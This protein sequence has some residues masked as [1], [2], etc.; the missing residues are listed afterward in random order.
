MFWIFVNERVKLYPNIGLGNCFL[1]ALTKINKCNL[2]KKPNIIYK[3][4][5]FFYHYSNAESSTEVTQLINDMY[6]QVS[7][8]TKNKKTNWQLH[9]IYTVTVV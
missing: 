9:F 5:N 3:Q 4:T 8:S 6:F 1:S 2:K 7:H